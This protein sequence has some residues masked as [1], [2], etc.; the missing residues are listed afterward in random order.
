M[1]TSKISFPK[2]FNPS[3]LTEKCKQN[4][5]QSGLN[6][7]HFLQGR[8]NFCI[9]LPPPNVT[10]V[11]HMGH[12]FNQT[13]M[14]TL[15]RYH[16]MLGENTLWVPGTD[17]AGIATQLVVER[18]LETKNKKKTDIGRDAF[19]NCI[20][21]WKDKSSK[22]IKSQ[23]KELGSSVDW[24]REYFTLDE[25]MSHAVNVAFVQLYQEGL[26]Y[27]GKRLVNWDPVLQT[28][29][30]DLEVSA[31]EE[32]GFMYYLRYP[33]KNSNLTIT[34]AT[35]RPET[36]FGDVAVM[37]H[38][39]DDRYR[40][41]IGEKIILPFSNREI[42][43]ISDPSVDPQFG[44]GAVKVTPAHDFNDYQ[45][46]KRHHLPIIEIFTLNGQ[47]NGN[48]TTFFQG[49]DIKRARAIVIDE[50]KNHKILVDIK[51]HKLMVPRN[52]RS[53]NVIEP[54][55][56]DQWFIAVNKSI[57]RKDGQMKSM[58][59]IAHDAS[60]N[61]E[62]EF[63]PENWVN[64]YNQ[65]LANIEDWCISRQLWWGH[66][67]P[68]WYGANKEIFVAINEKDAYAQAKKFGYTGKLIQDNDVLDTWFSSSLAPFSALGWPQKT[69]ELEHF[70]PS[71]VLVT[72][73]DIL[74][75]WVARMVMLTKHFTGKIP[76]QKVY[77]HG[78]VRDA[79]GQ[80]MSKSKGNVLDPIDII[81][82]IDLD[83]LVKKR[84]SHLLN[85]KQTDTIAKLT[86]KQFPQG[87]K[88]M[89][90]DALRFTFASM[91]TMGRNI[92]FDLARTEGY[93]NFCNKLWNATRFVLLNC[94]TEISPIHENKIE[95]NNFHTTQHNENKHCNFNQL[96]TSWWSL[97]PPSALCT[98]PL[99]PADEWI[100]TKFNIVAHEIQQH[101]ESLR[102]D[103]LAQTLHQFI[104]DEFC[105]WY[106]EIAKIQLI[107]KKEVTN[108]VLLYIL[109]GILRLSHPLIPFITE[110]LWQYVYQTVI[111][112]NEIK[113]TNQVSPPLLMA[114]PYPTCNQN[115]MNQQSQLWMETFK[116]I[117][118]ACRNL[119]GQL[120]LSPAK[121]VPLYIVDLKC[122]NSEYLTEISSYLLI[123]AKISEI[124][125]FNS[126]EEFDAATTNMS[127]A[128][129][130]PFKI[131]LFLDIDTAEEISRIKKE[132]GY[133]EIEINKLTHK[134]SNIAFI[135]KAPSHI[136]KKEKERLSELK[137][138][139]E[140]LLMKL[141]YFCEKNG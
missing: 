136:V 75:F 84:T 60:M 100:I 86:K 111:H 122:K 135:S 44:T 42:S 26:I 37:V 81:N 115:L 129:V 1:M 27:K 107:N 17:H 92:N 127:V 13:I 109:D 133:V 39:E 105:D 71:S 40:T 49:L 113:L 18:E 73:F 15:I 25:K 141:A 20:W 63:F 29:I 59:E 77:I 94:E 128:I 7:P 30:S 69:L 23:I 61:N 91:A 53:G 51:P 121:K 56:T 48:T 58:A 41:F 106:L 68:A 5:E 120:N 112:K 126:E 50:C 119:R 21:E 16:R 134:L 19:I 78:L 131:A 62:I 24:S 88:A 65:W 64:T 57:S 2:N 70:L 72:G 124:R 95:K 54:M 32:D 116:A 52:E 67:I 28:A 38:P 104:W 47:L 87:I 45:V 99:G 98:A 9:L 96:G 93:R 118:N 74:F 130:L 103:L 83:T 138:K 110:S 80:K 6:Q 139:K 36:I 31:V 35:T 46:A 97:I 125:I 137:T 66:R 82:G 90:I 117:V 85:P 33:L 11:L 132:L 3:E 43:I 89:G 79:S 140:N 22:T 10:G 114:Q 14:D 108:L 76:F 101:F 34:V 8:K 55:L 123:L 4:W 12:A 102:I